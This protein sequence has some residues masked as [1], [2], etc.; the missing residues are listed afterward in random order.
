M[1]EQTDAEKELDLAW[2]VALEELRTTALMGENTSDRVEA[3]KAII[4]YCIALGQSI[5]APYMP[6]DRPKVEEDD[7]EDDD[8]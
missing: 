8:E 7:D 3:A 2:F 5:N 4:S 1:A 6:T